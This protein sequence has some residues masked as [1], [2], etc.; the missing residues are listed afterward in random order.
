MVYKHFLETTTFENAGYNMGHYLRDNA[1]EFLFALRY[2]PFYWLAIDATYRYAEKG[3]DLQDD[4]ITRNPATGALVIQ[5]VPF[6]SQ[7]IWIQSSYQMQLTATPIYRWQ[8]F[9]SINRINRPVE[10]A[11]YQVPYLSG[12]QTTFSVGTHWGF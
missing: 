1:R 8:I 5:G 10:A 7:R 9:A 11:S 4:R 6:L 12:S 2:K 3:P